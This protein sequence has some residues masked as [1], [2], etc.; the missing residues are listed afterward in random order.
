MNTQL[1]FEAFADSTRRRILALLADQGE[2][3]VC[4]LTAALA[5]G[6]PKISRHLATLKEAG[7][8]IPR[9]AGTWMHYRLDDSVPQWV[10]GL[11]QSLCQ[12]AVAELAEDLE[13]LDRMYARPE[14]YAA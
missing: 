1:I 7:L 10:I 9:R 11:L 12:G 14:R 5:E 6:Q 4:E 13:R 3:C 8:V 2:L